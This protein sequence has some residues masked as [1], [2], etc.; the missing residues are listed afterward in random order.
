[1]FSGI[2]EEIGKVKSVIQRAGLL[3]LVITAKTALEGVVPG[4]SLS[5]NG[6]CLTVCHLGP[7][8]V[9]VEVIPE[10]LRLTNLGDLQVGDPINLERAITPMTRIG[11]H[12][13]QG[14][15]DGTATILRLEPQ[16]ESLKVWFQQPAFFRDCFIPKG[17]IALDGMSLTLVDTRAEAFSVCLIPHTQ[18]K[19]IVQLYKLGTKV[20]VE[21]DHMTKT[22]VHIINQ[23]IPYGTH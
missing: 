8:E 23:R 5:V 12:F 2:V 14:H 9:T 15:V 1:M 19:T 22:I 3:T 6:V 11:G 13:V 4:D 10:T 17:Y 7:G 20:N 18:Q 21:I 16:G